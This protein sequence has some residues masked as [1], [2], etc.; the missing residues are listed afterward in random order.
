MGKALLLVLDGAS[1]HIMMDLKQDLSFLYEIMKDGVFGNLQSVFPSIT[2]VALASLFSGKQPEHNGVTGPKIFIKNRPLSKPLSAFSSASLIEDPV[3]A[4]LARKG[5]KSI[6]LSAPQSLPD[7]WKIENMI[8]F[9]PYRAKMKGCDRGFLINEGENWIMEG[10]WKLLCHDDLCTLHYPSPEGEEEI[11]L[12]KSKWSNPFLIKATCKR[13]EL[14]GVTR[15]IQKD[16]K[17]YILPPAF[18]NEEWYNVKELGKDVWENV[19]IKEGMILD[20]DYHGLSSGIIDLEEYMQTV[21]FAFQF[22]LSY[23]KFVLNKYDWDFAITYLPL[24]DNL[25]HLLYGIDDATATEHIRRAY[26]LGDEFV[27]EHSSMGDNIIICSDHGIAKVRKKV[28]LNKFLER[29]NLLSLEGDRIN[30]KRTKAYYGGG[31]IIRINLVNREKY[32]IVSKKEFPKLIRYIMRNLESLE[33]PESRVR[34]FTSIYAN[35]VPAEDRKADIAIMGVTK[36]YSISSQIGNTDII[37]SVVPYRTS[38][39]DHGYYRAED[40][41]GVILMHGK[42]FKK[43]LKVNC[44][45]IDI[46][47]TILKIYNMDAKSDGRALTEVLANYGI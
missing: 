24:I 10:K 3:W 8:L 12:E 28:Y 14:I 35:E 47:P 46:M 19:S 33:D 32:G 6:V 41:D 37:E 11:E 23:S 39:A 30:W 25:Q 34:I 20:G 17:V 26:Q 9:D 45:I 15:A 40:M 13:K 43:G 31:G 29:I 16:N 7:K 18:D 27:R 42:D 2:P 44:R 22:F 36:G 38:S 4:H 5:Y 21:F 1:F